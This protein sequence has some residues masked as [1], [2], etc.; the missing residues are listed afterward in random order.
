MASKS[1]ATLS[2]TRPLPAKYTKGQAMPDLK[3]ISN[4]DY[5]ERS[6]SSDIQNF[7]ASKLPPGDRRE[8]AQEFKKTLVLAAQA[9]KGGRR[10]QNVRKSKK[11]LTAKERRAL[12]LFRLPRRGLSYP[13]FLPLHRLWTDYMAELLDLPGLE[14]SGWKPG[15]TEEPRQLQLQTRLCRADLHGALLKVSQA[16]CPSHRGVEGLVVMETKNTLQI[17]GRDNTLRIVPKLGSSF[18]YTVGGY[19]FTLPGSSIDSK[20]AERATKKLKNKT[21][22]DF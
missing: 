8:V 11:Q 3:D 15:L 16:A 7:L 21:P 1:F 9:P 17:L 12:G 13:S 10:K 14:A 4:G 18:T 22:L 19:I 6:D 20:P 5:S 2:Y